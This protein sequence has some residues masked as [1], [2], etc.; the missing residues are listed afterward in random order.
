MASINELFS[1]IVGIGNEEYPLL[2]KTYCPMSRV[3]CADF[4]IWIC[5]N[6]IE[7]NYQEIEALIWEIIQANPGIDVTFGRTTEDS[8]YMWKNHWGARLRNILETDLSQYIK[9]DMPEAYLDLR[10]ALILALPHDDKFTDLYLSG[11]MLPYTTN[12]LLPEV[13]CLSQY[14]KDILKLLPLNSRI[15]MLDIYTLYLC[16][17]EKSLLAEKSIFYATREKGVHLLSSIH[18]LL[19]RGLIERDDS[20]D[21]RLNTYSKDALIAEAQKA[22][23][24]A[25]SSWNKGKLISFIK[26]PLRMW[27]KKCLSPYF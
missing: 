12:S 18:L 8:S 5:S 3:P 25:T 23:L 9:F 27:P 6:L 16:K 13:S 20:I 1:S 24:N 22:G 19:Q 17:H 15:H 2:H 21:A 7:H 14:F 26:T 4:S 10:V 11:V